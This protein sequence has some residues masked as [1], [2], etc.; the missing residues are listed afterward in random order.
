MKIPIALVIIITIIAQVSYWPGA[1]TAGTKLLRLG[2]W[3]KTILIYNFWCL[4][5]AQISRLMFS[6]ATVGHIIRRRLLGPKSS[7]WISRKAI[8]LCQADRWWGHS[9]CHSHCHSPMAV[10]CPTDRPVTISNNSRAISISSSTSNTTI[11]P[12]PDGRQNE[13]HE[14]TR[15]KCLAFI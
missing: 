10:P 4:G 9:R 11:R 6:P 5:S 13:I 1:Y 3:W 8:C 15:P 2:S 14:V 12:I 7:S